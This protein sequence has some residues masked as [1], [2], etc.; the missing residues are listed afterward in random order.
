MVVLHGI[1]IFLHFSLSF[2][3]YNPIWMWAVHHIRKLGVF[4][5]PAY[6]R[7]V[8]IWRTAPI[9]D[10]LYM[11]G[12]TVVLFP[13]VWIWLSSSIFGNQPPQS[14]GFHYTSSPCLCLI[15]RN[16]SNY[17]RGTSGALYMARVDSVEIEGWVG[18][19][20]VSHVV[21]GGS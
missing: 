7:T 1:G 14:S 10:L 6:T 3:H 2:M 4:T 16:I 20:R 13:R 18:G 19:L 5:R 8:N 12:R 21:D 11:Q 17:Y 15:L 9:A